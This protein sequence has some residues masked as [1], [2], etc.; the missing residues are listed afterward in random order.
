MTPLEA[1][2][3]RRNA[4]LRAW[5]DYGLPVEGGWTMEKGWY[6]QPERHSARLLL[7]CT[8]CPSVEYGTWLCFSEDSTDLDISLTYYEHLH[9]P[10][11]SHLEPLLEPHD[12]EEVQALTACAL[13][14]VL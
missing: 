12:P 3:L 2:T 14:E 4:R 10:P 7:R 5:R 1:E 11:C 13:L 6:D 9:T 8:A